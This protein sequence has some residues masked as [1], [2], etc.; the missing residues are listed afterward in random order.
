MKEFEA[1]LQSFFSL[2]TPAIIHGVSLADVFSI[3]LIVAVA[4]IGHIEEIAI[5][6]KAPYCTISKDLL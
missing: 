4:G 1:M 6:E 3:F 2:L 5:S